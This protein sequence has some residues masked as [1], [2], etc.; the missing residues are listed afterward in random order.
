[1][2]AEL[3]DISDCKKSFEIEVPK[4]VVDNEITQIA[5]EF[6]RRAKVPGFRPGKAPVPVV[7]TRFREEI[8]SE[9]LQHLLPK[10]F[11]EAVKEQSLDIV[12]TPHFQSID[13]DAGKPLKFTATFEVYPQL[14]ISNY[15]GVP[16]REIP[17]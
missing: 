6:A 15:S 11:S 10:S 1:M 13:Y 2:K 9:M 5:R 3:T 4:E 16:V 12:E 17:T 7:K 14:K 8:V